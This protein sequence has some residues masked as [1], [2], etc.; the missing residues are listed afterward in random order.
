MQ[1]TKIVQEILFNGVKAGS[2]IDPRRL[3]PLPHQ[4]PFTHLCASTRNPARSTLIEVI[5]GHFGRAH[6]TPSSIKQKLAS[7]NRS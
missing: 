3:P 7:L 6:P 2:E 5:P 1:Y 4:P